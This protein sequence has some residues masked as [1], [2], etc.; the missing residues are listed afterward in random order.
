MSFFRNLS[1]VRKLLAGFALLILVTGGVGVVTMQKVFEVP[2]S[3]RAVLRATGTLVA[4]EEVL[5]GL[6]HE[7]GTLRAYLLDA[8]AGKADSLAAEAETGRQALAQ[9]QARVSESPIQAQRFEGIGAAIE[10]WRHDTVEKA[11]ALAET[12]LAQARALEAGGRQSVDELRRKLSEIAQAE[13]D[14]LGGLGD[15]AQTAASDMAFTLRLGVI[16]SLVIT[17]A[18]AWVLFRAVAHPVSEM[19]AAMNC[20]AQ[21]ETAV[22]IFGTGR[23]DEIGALGR[24]IDMFRLHV[25]GKENEINRLAAAQEELEQQ[26][27]QDQQV[28]DEQIA[29]TRRALEAETELRIAALNQQARTEIDAL[30]QQAQNEKD[31]LRRQAQ[32][33]KEALEAALRLELGQELEALALRAQAEK[34]ALEASAREQAAELERQLEAER[35][36]ARDLIRDF[37]ARIGTLA[38][39]LQASATQMETAAQSMSETAD[40]ASQRTEGAAASVAETLA[41]VQAILDAAS[42]LSGSIQDVG[43][44]TADGITTH[45]AQVKTATRDVVSVVDGIGSLLEELRRISGEGQDGA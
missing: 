44:Q 9:L 34:E 8:G 38:Q 42:A 39:A 15:A 26:L 33:E 25:R 21:G 18:V 14:S 19:V 32:G 27:L 28:L 29:A 22:E 16:A 35:Q 43:R 23:Q 40:T 6:T 4:A 10:G 45:I 24:A 5:A 2:G 7:E 37:E 13:R 30:T 41:R 20:I 12:D 17:V 31:D 11:V 3:S 36:R 1:I